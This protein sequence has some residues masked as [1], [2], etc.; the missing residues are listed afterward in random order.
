MQYCK[1]TLA[2]AILIAIANTCIHASV[3][4]TTLVYGLPTVEIK[5][6]KNVLDSGKITSPETVI[7]SDDIKQRGIKEQKQLSLIVPNLFMPDY[8]S[9]MTSTIYMRGFGSR[10]DNPVLGLYVDD[11]PIIDKN[12]YDFDYFDIQNIKVYSGPQS[13]L[14]GRNS[15]MGV[16]DITTPSPDGTDKGSVNVEYGKENWISTHATYYTKH[17]GFTAGYRHCD[18][19]FRNEYNGDKADKYNAFSFMGKYHSHISPRL[20]IDNS[21]S[22]SLLKQGG[23]AYSRFDGSKLQPISYNDASSYKRMSLIDGLKLKFDSDN[24][25]LSSI[26]SFQWL[27]DRMFLDN[28]FTSD[29]MFTLKQKQHQYAITEELILQSKKHPTW[30][31][32]QTGIFFMYK[33]NNLK[34][35]VELHKQA[36]DQLILDGINN[37]FIER[38]LPMRLNFAEDELSISDDFKLKN[39]DIAIYHESYFT[40][41]RWLL[42][43]GVRLDYEHNSMYYNCDATVHYFMY[44]F[45]TEESSRGVN[46]A[47]TGNVHHGYVQLLPKISMS[48]DVLGNVKGQNN[49]RFV[50]SVSKGFKAGGYN[51]QIFSDIMR[52]KL[53]TDMMIDAGRE[54]KESYNT[55]TSESTTYKP[56]TCVSYELGGIYS[57]YS[58]NGL[59]FYMSAAGFLVNSNNMQITVIPPGNST[60]RIMTNAGKARSIGI[61]ITTNLNYQ[62]WSFSSSFGLTNAYFRKY[63]DGTDNFSDNKVPYVP[64]S[65]FIVR[66]SHR[67]ALG[68]N[69]VEL[70][71]EGTQTG[72]MWWNESNSLHQNNYFLLNTDVTL[73][74]HRLSIY[75]RAE[76]I[77]STEYK[78]FYFKSVGNEFYQKG[79]PFRWTIGCSFR[80]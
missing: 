3:V 4:D 28:D 72:K 74:I 19:F 16:I 48:Y 60:G 32:Q 1:T 38:G 11:V 15:M 52:N 26:T 73:N 25:T 50:A 58:N 33:H 44:P 59:T 69:T 56:E 31:N 5:S 49:L 57:H 8:G 14:Y 51:T 24:F 47:Y 21:L 37:I 64:Q 23:Y 78:T 46:S 68:R 20:S 41:N 55:I 27:I 79:K 22:L 70:G 6:L 12:N 62:N 53:K 71:I 9:F 34:A 2:T 29:N 77:T 39:T 35:P 10:I 80:L 76:N 13:T 30:W 18:G 36:I 67:L 17:F 43:A 75:G 7:T 61:E 45:M 63:I 54:V 40:L 66:A 42:T 65:T